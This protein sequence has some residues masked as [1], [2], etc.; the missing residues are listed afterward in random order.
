MTSAP[1]RTN[2]KATVW[3]WIERWPV[4]VWTSFHTGVVAMCFCDPAMAPPWVP[5]S[6]VCDSSAGA[7]EALYSVLVRRLI[8]TWSLMPLRCEFTTTNSS[9]LCPA[10]ASKSQSEA[11]GLQSVMFAKKREH[12]AWRFFFWALPQREPLLPA[13][14]RLYVWVAFC[15]ECGL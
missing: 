4:V 8:A 7:K 11:F 5:K 10:T 1:C 9:G 3:W 6:L 13:A 12:L 14:L 15:A 2:W